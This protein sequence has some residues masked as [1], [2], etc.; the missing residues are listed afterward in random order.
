M[1]GCL[2][3]NKELKAKRYYSGIIFLP[4]YAH[5]VFVTLTR[6][7]RHIQHHH[8]NVISEIF[9]CKHT[10]IEFIKYYQLFQPSQRHQQKSTGS[11]LGQTNIFYI[12]TS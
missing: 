12:P 9:I 7:W 1:P 5:A 3:R 6:F 10:E 4:N 8:Q 11:H 2:L